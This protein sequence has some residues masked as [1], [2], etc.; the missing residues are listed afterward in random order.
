MTHSKVMQ[1]VV[2]TQNYE[3][4]ELMQSYKVKS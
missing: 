3:T 2:L 1:Y 4:C